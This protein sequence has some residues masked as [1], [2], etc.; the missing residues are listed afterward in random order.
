MRQRRRGVP[1]GLRGTVL[2]L[3]LGL[4]ARTA[5]VGAVQVRVP[6]L[7]VAAP[8]PQGG[9]APLAVARDREVPMK[10]VKWKRVTIDLSGAHWDDGRV[11]C[12]LC[13]CWFLPGAEGVPSFVHYASGTRTV[14]CL[15]CA[16][17]A[18]DARCAKETHA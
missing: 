5:R 6:D 8:S 10:T 14:V 16:L 4:D 9:A 18:F 15:A 13:G 7:L 3:L 1:D 12:A 11:A 17:A 2:A